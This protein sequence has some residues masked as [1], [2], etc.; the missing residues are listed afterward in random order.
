MFLK[1]KIVTIKM[2]QDFCTALYIILR[3][4]RRNCAPFSQRLFHGTVGAWLTLPTRFIDTSAAKFSRYAIPETFPFLVSLL[5]A[6]CPCG[7]AIGSSDI[8]ATCSLCNVI[9]VDI[10]GMTCLCLIQPGDLR[11]RDTFA[12]GDTSSMLEIFVSKS[13]VPLRNRC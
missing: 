12:L 7:E 2:G 8:V 5:P 3:N 11:H 10:A 6:G 1:N 4:Y 13:L 9:G